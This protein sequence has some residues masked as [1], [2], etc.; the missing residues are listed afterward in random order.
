MW[1][2]KQLDIGWLD[3][4]AGLWHGVAAASAATERQVVPPRWFPPEQA[5]LTLS[6]R[7]AWDLYLSA[8]NLPPGSEVILSAVTIPDMARIIE[9]HGLTPVPVGID[10]DSLQVDAAEVERALS[11]QTRAILVAHLFGSRMELGAI[12]EVANRYGLLLIED[13]A[14]AFV[15]GSYAGHPDSDCVLW[16]FGPIKTATALGGAVARVADDV[17][18][19]RMIAIHERYP[20]QSRGSYFKR[21]AKYSAFRALSWPPTY[22]LLVRVLEG[23]G[24]EYDRVLGN[25]AHSFAASEL[26]AQLRHRPSKPLSRMLSRRIGRFSQHGERKLAHRAARGIALAQALPNLCVVGSSNPTHTYWVLP[27]VVANGEA[28]V[29]ALRA[30]GFDATC[31]SS[32]IVVRP[33]EQPLSEPD[34]PHEPAQAPWLAHTLF[35]PTAEAMSEKTWQR[36]IDT[37]QQ[38]ATPAPT[39]NPEPALSLAATL[40]GQSST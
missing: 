5:I 33:N 3:L 32:L 18:R 7:T 34:L 26:F 15:G 21:L 20:R 22:G 29:A 37:V 30:A 36:L 14:Q 1:P 40:P 6:V 17:V 31:R 19:N 27:I 39:I 16:S 2:R 13:C 23:L 11:P 10:A 9:H 28:V 25:A 8:L 12:A 35:L 24:F 4:V 38:H